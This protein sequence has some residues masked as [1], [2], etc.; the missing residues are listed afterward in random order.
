VVVSAFAGLVLVDTDDGGDRTAEF[1]TLL[2]LA[3]LG[4][5]TVAALVLAGLNAVGVLSGF[6]TPY[7]YPLLPLVLSFGVAAYL[8]YGRRTALFHRLVEASDHASGLADR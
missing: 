1:V 7:L 4:F 6:G 2:V 5:P 3:G 8:T